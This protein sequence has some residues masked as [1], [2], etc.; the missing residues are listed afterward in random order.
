MPLARIEEPLPTASAV[1]IVVLS[2]VI[3][4][5]LVACT[6]ATPLSVIVPLLRVKLPVRSLKLI[7]VLLASVLVSPAMVMSAGVLSM[8]TELV[9]LVVVICPNSIVP[10][11]VWISSPSPLVFVIALLVKV[12]SPVP[13][14]IET[15][16]PPVLLIVL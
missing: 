15:A 12:T 5:E 11:A 6:P 2:S 3:S 9:P 16:S 7:A 4:D 13:P 10:A 14:L 1:L 8:L